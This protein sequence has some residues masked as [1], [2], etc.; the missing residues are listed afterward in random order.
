MSLLLCS[1]EL[2]SLFTD[3]CFFSSLISSLVSRLV[4]RDCR[5]FLGTECDC[6]LFFVLFRCFHSS[7]WITVDI[8]IPVTLDIC[9][10]GIVGVTTLGSVEYRQLK[11]LSNSEWGQKDYSNLLLSQFLLLR[12]GELF[13]VH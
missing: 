3:S 4:L 9:H 6:S 2:A 11:Q 8:L 13:D 10:R 12:S 1:L 5:L 7:P